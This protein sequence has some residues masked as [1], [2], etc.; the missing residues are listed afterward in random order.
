MLLAIPIAI[1]CSIAV[2][3]ALVYPQSS[4]PKNIEYML[5]KNGLYRI[6]LDAA[7]DAIIG[8]P[9]V[10]K[11]VVGQTKDQLRRRFGY[12]Q[13]PAESMGYLKSCHQWPVA[14]DKDAL[15]IRRST[16]MVVFDGETATQLILVKGC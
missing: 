13:T 7:T 10:S 4:D 12:L 14:K 1:L 9:N 15:F 5:W 6:N 3:W 8:D 2:G 16:W 11:L